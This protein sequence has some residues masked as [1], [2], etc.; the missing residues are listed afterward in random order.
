MRGEEILS[1]AQRIHEPQ[2]LIQEMRKKGINPDSMKAY[3]DAFRM[4]CPPHG[5]GG[6]GMSMHGAVWERTESHVSQAWSAC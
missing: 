5:G 6:I 4:G 2:L 3:V 1:G